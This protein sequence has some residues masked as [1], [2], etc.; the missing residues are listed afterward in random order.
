VWTTEIIRRRMAGK[1]SAKAKACQNKEGQG[2]LRSLPRPRKMQR[3]EMEVDKKEQQKVHNDLCQKCKWEDVPQGTCKTLVKG[4]TT[5]G[6]R[7]KIW[8]RCWIT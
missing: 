1:K 4:K 5:A 8:I 2:V 3:V 6:E 7:L